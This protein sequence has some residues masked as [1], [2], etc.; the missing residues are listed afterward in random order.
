VLVV[1]SGGGSR[2]RILRRGDLTRRHT[3][4][5]RASI[6]A[7]SPDSREIAFL[8]N[9]DK[10]EAISTNSDIIVMKIR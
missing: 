10:I 4:H 3:V 8:K 1:S 7:F 9:P 6:I 5:R 2:V